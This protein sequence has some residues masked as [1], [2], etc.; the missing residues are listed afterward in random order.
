MANE[1]NVFQ[2][3]LKK[4]QSDQ[5]DHRPARYHGSLMGGEVL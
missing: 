4:F 1:T 3:T 5:T 2:N